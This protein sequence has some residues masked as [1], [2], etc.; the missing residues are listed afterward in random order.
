MST[1][2]QRL[3]INS[4]IVF[5]EEDEGAFLF[6]PNTGRLC[7]LNETGINIWK[8]CQKHVTQ[9]QI[10]KEICAGYPQTPQNQVSAD[11]EIFIKDLKGLGFLLVKAEDEQK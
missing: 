6:D 5:R 4:E 1:K 7:Y 2:N 3:R 9:A 8:F 10:I 11:C